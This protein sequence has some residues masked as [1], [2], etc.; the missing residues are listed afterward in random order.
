MVRGLMHSLQGTVQLE[1]KGFSPERFLNLCSLNGIEIWDL[2]YEDGRCRLSM[3]LPDFWKI[4]AFARKS[5]VRVKVTKRSGLPFF[6]EKNRK[7]K[8]YLLG[9]VSFFVL[10]YG[11][12]LFIWDI[13]FIG[14]YH[15]TDDT[16]ETFLEDRGIAC[17]VGKGSVDCEEL[18]A[19]LRSGFPEITWVSARVSGTRLYIQVK[20]NEVLSEIRER[21]SAPCNIVADFSGT[22]TEMIVR[23][24]VPMVSVGDTVEEGQLLVS[25]GVPVTNDNEEVV[26]NNL[27][28]ADADITARSSGSYR[29]SFPLLHSVTVD[30][31]KLRM[32]MYFR[33]GPFTARFLLPPKAESSW[34]TSSQEYQVCLFSDFCLPVWWGI[35]RSSQCVSYERY[36]TEKELKEK[37]EAIHQ[38]YLKNLSEK[39]VHIIE[40]NVKILED[41]S[42]CHVEGSFVGEGPVG[43]AEAIA[44]E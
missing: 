21:E 15:Y 3:R 1:M 19:A 9:A 18:E 31:G 36:Y 29:Q 35:I 39:G 42:L 44:G 25:G 34:R 14:N 4:R 17:G 23:S 22:I 27:V 43:R 20:E 7:R 30:T 5:G 8:W 41:A 33:I 37:G 28:R 40:N 11:L 32:G 10:L 16:L 2:V 12:S 26:K 38:T 6:V 13:S 24:G